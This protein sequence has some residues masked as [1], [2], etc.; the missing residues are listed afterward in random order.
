MVAFM[1]WLIL[2]GCTSN[3]AQH[4]RPHVLVVVMDTVRADHLSLYGHY[5]TTTPQLRSLARQ[6]VTFT[7]V[8]APS[9]W[10]WPSHASLFTGEPPWVHGARFSPAVGDGIPLRSDALH[11]TPMRT[12]LPTLAEQFT[13]NGYHSVALS[14]NRLL[15]P[16]LGLTRGFEV[17]KHFPSDGLL[18]QEALA[19][20]EKDTDRPL[21]LFINLMSAHGPYYAVDKA[22]W[23]RQHKPKLQQENSPEWLIPYLTKEAP[24]VSL[25]HKHGDIPSAIDRY[26]RGELDIPQSDLDLLR[27]L[28]DGEILLVDQL[29]SQ[30]VGAWDQKFSNGVVAITS[31]HGEYFGEHH[32]LEH[33][34]TVYPEVLHVPLILRAP[35]I[36]PNT[37]INH[38]VQ[39][40]DLYPTLLKLS[41]I[42]PDQ[43][44][45]LLDAPMS[46]RPIMAEARM[47]PF[48]AANIGGIFKES[49]RLYREG[50]LALI[51]SSGD[52]KYLYN[53]STDPK[54]NSDLSQDHPDQLEV[55]YQKAMM[56]F[57]E[58]PEADAGIQLDDETLSHLK[59]LGYIGD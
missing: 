47:D 58:P 17:A 59:A 33:G 21:F 49:W 45:P 52:Q 12:D 30:L 42:K 1:V 13:A 25:T 40:Q 16:A 2:W 28:Y 10:T 53:V 26:H 41:G 3:P 38:P 22:P 44:T 51:F 32:L 15:S 19:L 6:G 29:V 43:K 20:L 55:L 7:D 46:S 35:S 18:I 14:A 39:L 34:R 50:D 24:G 8:T 57:T 31:D 36:E 11:V 23:I 48:W 37:K 9:S 27:D 54:M 56:A 5:R 4:S